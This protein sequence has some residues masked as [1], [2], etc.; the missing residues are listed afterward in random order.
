MRF[1]YRLAAVTAA[2]VLALM[3]AIVWKAYGISRL[4]SADAELAR[5]SLLLN[6]LKNNTEA[7]LSIG[8]KLD[9]ISDLQDQI[10][11]DKHSDET[12]LAIDIYNGNGTSIYATDRGAIGDRVPAQWKSELKKKDGETIWQTVDFKE[13]VFGRHFNDDLGVAGGITV[14][15]SRKSR[16]ERAR[17]TLWDLGTLAATMGLL[18]L[19]MTAGCTLWFASRLT[20]PIRRVGLILAGSAEPAEGSQLESLAG[21]AKQSIAAARARTRDGLRKLQACDDIG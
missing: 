11:R 3:A 20:K 1:S 16:D 21:Q 4:I 9:Q 10:E 19:V 5:V 13:P 7:R 8:L 17:A 18:A 14:T 15:V 6:T 2:C 12:V